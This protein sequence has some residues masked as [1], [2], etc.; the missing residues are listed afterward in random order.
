MIAAAQAAADGWTPSN[1]IALVAI[2]V[3]AAGVV[4]AQLV[5]WRIREEDRRDQHRRE[6]A[7]ALGPVYSVLSEANALVEDAGD[8]LPAFRRYEALTADWR[9]VKPAI[10][11]MAL[12]YPDPEVRNLAGALALAV[13]LLL[14]FGIHAAAFENI[15]PEGE[16]LSA[17]DLGILAQSGYRRLQKAKVLLAE[18]AA[19]IRGDSTIGAAA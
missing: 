17:E 2:V 18:L 13:D 12:S 7:L 14:T 3:G 15:G 1:T 10:M 19:T 16:T 4:V 6:A 11:A 8:N 9:K 5:Q